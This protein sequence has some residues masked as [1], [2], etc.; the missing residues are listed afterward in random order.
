MKKFLTIIPVLAVAL[1]QTA[2]GADGEVTL[3]LD[4]KDYA[5]GGQII[6]TVKDVTEKMSSDKAFV[7]VYRQGAAH[8][9][10]GDYKYPKKGT[11]VMVFDTPEYGLWE[12]RF[13]TQDGKYDDETLG[14]KTSFSVGGAKASDKPVVK[15]DKAVYE[16]G[17][18]MTAEILGITAQMVEDKAFVGIYKPDAEHNDW[19]EYQ[20]PRHN[21][22]RLDYT[23]P[24]KDGA[25]EMRLYRKDGEY[26]DET[27]VLRTPFA[28][29]DAPAE[30]AGDPSKLTLAALYAAA[31]RTEYEME[32]F[33]SPIATQGKAKPVDG[34]VITFEPENGSFMLDFW[35]F[36]NEADAKA[37]K[38]ANDEPEAMFPK[39]H[40]VYGR[41]MAKGSRGFS[42][43]NDK[44]IEDF[45]NGIFKDA[46]ANPVVV[47]ENAVAGEDVGKTPPEV[48][49][50]LKNYSI[51]IVME[52][53]GQDP[54][55]IRQ[56]ASD[57]GFFT[58][59]K[60]AR[61]KKMD[62]D[63]NEILAEH[64]EIE[65]AD[66]TANKAYGLDALK[67]TG[68]AESFPAQ[69][70]DNY[71]GFGMVVG[72]LLFAHKDVKT[73]VPAGKEKFLDRDTTVYTI[74]LANGEEQ[75][76]WLDNEYGFTL[77]MEQTKPKLAMRV[78]ELKI[79]GAKAEGLVNVGEY[80]VSELGFEEDDE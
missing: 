51:S 38:A 50:V 49:A 8:N 2:F 22:V 58:E 68:E 77:K 10:Y 26:T 24:E 1:T 46:L 78:T 43:K 11:S 21:A 54:V 67:K 71:R 20:Y 63:F 65:F 5:E 27:L 19:G 66:F 79:G 9:A 31:K 16:A 12:I 57:K 60:C 48:Q 23:A 47:D 14:A 13:Y 73:M 42:E 39:Y 74:P 69:Y 29:G 41:F 33:S 36:K 30:V 7:A 53:E 32:G 17:E 44:A 6:V 59:T 64:H 3:S 45:L 37:F 28:V 55:H 40:L 72:G 34:F 70:A 18:K 56:V 80:K 15:L 52:S 62:D 75:K 35:E 25:Y 4:K 76:L 61:M